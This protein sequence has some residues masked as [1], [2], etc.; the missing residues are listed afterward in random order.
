[1]ILLP[2]FVTLLSF[3]AE[4]QGRV[5][6]LV[7]NLR[8]VLGSKDP[9]ARM[10]VEF[11]ICGYDDCICK[12]NGSYLQDTISNDIRICAIPE[13]CTHWNCWRNGEA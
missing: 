8:W 2:V 9:R 5:L 12:D 3:F 7:S 13:G 11:D 4:S 1:M 6:E 10:K